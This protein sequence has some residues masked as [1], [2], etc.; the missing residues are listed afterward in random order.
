MGTP[1]AAAAVTLVF[2]A[3]GY[4]G[5]SGDAQ[6]YVDQ[7]AQAVVAAAGWPAGS[8]SAL[9]EP[10]EAGGLAKLAR[11]DAALV[12]VPYPFFV[13]HAVRLHLAALVAADVADTGPRQRWTLVA[14]R[15]RISGPAS[16]SGLAIV[17]TAGYAPEFLRRSALAA[18]ALPPDVRIEPTGQ[19]LS[20][21]RRV[22]AGEPVVVL[23][24]QTQAA[25]LASLPFAGELQA[26]LQSPEVPVAV[27]AVVDSRLGAARVRTLRSGLL[28]LGHEPG[29]AEL[30]AAM[31]LRGFVAPE[32]PGLT[33]AP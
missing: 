17:S 26:V 12:F 11:P 20:A 19:V 3:P 28:R 29:N 21:L 24:D 15:G 2:C 7:F 10:T 25:A 6:P 18:W 33:A 27:L 8:L 22:A 14:R 13:E 32:L 5:E 16:L 31:R 4:P 23:L 30:L 9:Y 1:L